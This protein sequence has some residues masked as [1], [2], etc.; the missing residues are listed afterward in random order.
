MLQPTGKVDA[1]A[2]AS[3]AT[4]DDEVVL[5]VDG[6][7]GEA[8]HRPPAAFPAAH[9]GRRR[10]RRLAGASRCGA[11]GPRS[12]PGTPRRGR[13]ARAGR[14]AGGRGRRPARARRRARPPVSLW[15]PSTPTRRC[16]SAAGVPGHGRRADRRHDP[17]RGR[18]ADDRRLGQLHEGLLHR[19]GAGGPHR[20]PRRQRPPPPARPRPRRARVGR[21]RHHGGGRR[22]RGRNGH[23]VRARAGR[24]APSP[25]RSSRRAVDPP[26]EATV[27]G[28]PATILDLPLPG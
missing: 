6:G 21:A 5:D 10:P 26:A 12:P 1:W 11:P 3:S 7:Y 25:S 19:P 20:Q 28:E 18:P 4:A 8:L 27:G 24:A 17:C 2:R 9:Q 16:A 15:R 13:A 22:R 23:L 14:V